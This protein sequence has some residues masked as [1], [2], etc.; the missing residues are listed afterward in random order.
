[1]NTE[2]PNLK[3]NIFA[4][5]SATGIAE[6]LTLP[7]C[8][9][10]TNFQVQSHQTIST[11][12]KNIYAKNGLVG[13]YNASF[14]AI[15]SQMISTAGKYSLYQWLKDIAR[16]D[17]ELKNFKFFNIARKDQALKNTTSN[18]YLTNTICGLTSGLTVSLFTHPIDFIRFN[19]QVNNKIRTE[20]QN[21]GI[22]IIYRGYSK[23]L[24]KVVLTSSLLF[25]VY[26]QIKT[27]LNNYQKI[28]SP[29]I[30]SLTASL[31]CTTIIHPVDYMKTVYITGNKMSHNFS[32]KNIFKYYRG[33]LLNLSRVTPHFMITMTLTEKF[34]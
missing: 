25:P 33:Y 32:F 2:R 28:N 4:S 17:Q 10:K 20:I 30:A 18:T 13:F 6:I 1:M 19:W 29:L 21:H 27:Y 34:L 11:V 31:I 12:I 5:A 7:I 15:G 3:K 14:P 16:K 24:M 26:D 8:A 23:N 22:R 9:I